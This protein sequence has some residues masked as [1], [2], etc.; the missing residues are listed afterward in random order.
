MKNQ[1]QL[2]HSYANMSS[3][4]WLDPHQPFSDQKHSPLVN[5]ND[6]TPQASPC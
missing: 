4:S 6:G 1:I 3:K 5:D 2:K